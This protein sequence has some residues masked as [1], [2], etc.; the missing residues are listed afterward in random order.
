MG[1]IGRLIKTEI[2]KYILQTVETHYGQNQ[3]C[4]QYGPSGEDAPPI[5]DDRVLL[6]KVEGSGRFVSAGVLTQSQDAEPGDKKMYSRD[7][8]SG[9]VKA[10][11]WLKND[12]S[13]EIESKDKISIKAGADVELDAGSNN[14]TFKGA[15]KVT[16]VSFEAGGTVAPSGTGCLCGLPYCAFTGAPQSGSKSMG[17]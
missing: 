9:D 5:K 15:V 1:R 11:I 7:S 10:Y 13:I 4:D 2:D 17:T 16:G 14:V 8:D 6:V 3:L 12:G